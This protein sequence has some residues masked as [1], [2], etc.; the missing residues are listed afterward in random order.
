ME[1]YKFSLESLEEMQE[2]AEQIEKEGLIRAPKSM[3]WSILEAAH[4]SD[5]IQERAEVARVVPVKQKKRA[6]QLM[7]YR[8][9]ICGAMAA[10]LLV[11]VC[12]TQMET[13]HRTAL[14]EKSGTVLEQIEEAR[15]GLSAELE[16]FSRKLFEWKWEVAR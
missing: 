10:S 11:L 3:K 12:T 2:L 7:I 8:M 6:A 16:S 1:Q 15:V 5:E 13:Y 4:A 14:W 9:K